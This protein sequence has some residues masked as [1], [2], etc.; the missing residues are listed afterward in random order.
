[1]SR[2]I[3][4]KVTGRIILQQLLISDSAILLSFVIFVPNSEKVW[5]MFSFKFVKYV[6]QELI[7]KFPLNQYSQKYWSN[8]KYY[9]YWI[10]HNLFIFN[11]N[12]HLYSICLSNF[13]LN[14]IDYFS[15]ELLAS[16]IALF[17]V[18]WCR[19]LLSTLKR[20]AF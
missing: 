12:L 4:P 5:L 7:T 9:I 10:N 6:F 8:S 17:Y 11:R 13:G 2:T 15:S 16:W 19:I 18:H 20:E 14:L 1:M 3:F